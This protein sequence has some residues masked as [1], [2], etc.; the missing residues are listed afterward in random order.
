MCRDFCRSRESLQG[1]SQVPKN[2]VCNKACSLP[3]FQQPRRCSTLSVPSEASCCLWSSACPTPSY[4]PPVLRNLTRVP[5]FFTWH[6]PCK[7]YRADVV[8][9]PLFSDKIYPVCHMPS[10]PQFPLPNVYS[11]ISTGRWWQYLWPYQPPMSML[12]SKSWLPRVSESLA[13]LP[14]AGLF[15]FHPHPHTN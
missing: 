3:T 15:G 14:L 8:G 1:N 2:E 7:L 11:S 10:G 13:Y 9:Y 12:L 6:R 4:S 5:E